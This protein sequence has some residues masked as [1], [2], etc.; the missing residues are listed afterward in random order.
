MDGSFDVF[1]GQY[2]EQKISVAE[3]RISLQID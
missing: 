1:I 3:F 2:V